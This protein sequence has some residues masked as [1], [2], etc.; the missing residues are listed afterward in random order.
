MKNSRIF[1]V[2]IIL[3]IAIA[4]FGLYSSL[5]KDDKNS[6]NESSKNLVL[7]EDNYQDNINEYKKVKDVFSIFYT[8]CVYINLDNK[9]SMYYSKNDVYTMLD[10]EYIDF[11]SINVNNFWKKV[12]SYVTEKF[13]LESYT[14][15][16]SKDNVELYLLDIVGL[17]QEN[18]K[19]EFL[20][21]LDNTNNTFSIY[22]EDYIKAKGYTNTNGANNK[23]IKLQNISKMSCNNFNET[24]YTKKEFQNDLFKEFQRA[25]ISNKEDVYDNLLEKEYRNSNFKNVNEF[26]EYV[27]KNIVD[28]ISMNVSNSIAKEEGNYVE[29]VYDTTKNI[30]IKIVVDSQNVFNYTVTIL[31]ENKDE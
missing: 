18:K 5:N 2:F 23:N 15:L 1:I 11:A 17:S 21:K 13:R 9:D 4:V 16:K 22:L 31:E 10:Q 8:A 29:I 6:S 27:K 25:C 20:L 19:M 28:I 24:Y 3:L 30:R 7:N 14:M 12:D 26:S